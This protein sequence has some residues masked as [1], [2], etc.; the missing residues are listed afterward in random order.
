[1]DGRWRRAHGAGPEGG[2]AEVLAGLT[3]SLGAKALGYL[4]LFQVT[5]RKGETNSRRYRKNGYVHLKKMVGCQAAFAGKPSSYRDR[6]TLQ[7][8]DKKTAT[9]TQGRGFLYLHNYCCNTVARL[10]VP[11][12]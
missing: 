11:N 7:T 2:H 12:C 4:A 6:S 5:R 9:L 8:P 3:I 1:M 10:S